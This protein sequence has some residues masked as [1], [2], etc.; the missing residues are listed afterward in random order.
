MHS[1]ICQV[2]K[3]LHLYIAMNKTDPYLCEAYTLVWGRT[4]NH[5]YMTMLKWYSIKLQ[6]L[7]KKEK[8]IGQGKESRLLGVRVR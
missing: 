6:V 2:F 7:W 3:C 5:K 1:F 4:V 8:S